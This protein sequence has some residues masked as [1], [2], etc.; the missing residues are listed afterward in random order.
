MIGSM[1]PDRRFE[2]ERRVPLATSFVR[3][4]A[5][6]LVLAALAACVGCAPSVQ[7]DPGGRRAEQRIVFTEGDGESVLP[8]LVAPFHAYLEGRRIELMGARAF[9]YD[10]ADPNAF[11]VAINKFYRDHPGFCPLVDAFAAAPDGQ[12]FLTLASDGTTS[13]KVFL[14]DHSERPQLTFAFADATS[15]RVLPVTRCETAPQ[16]DE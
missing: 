6:W 14:Y 5:R 13:I 7:G 2:G 1:S 10:G 16:A 9:R 11:V 4:L 3:S 8:T 15:A 12:R